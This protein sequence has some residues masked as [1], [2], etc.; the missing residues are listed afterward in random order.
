[1]T[2]GE[3]YKELGNLDEAL[4]SILKSQKLSPDNPDIYM[5]L[6]IIYLELGKLDQALTSTLNL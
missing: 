1:M 2:L 6:G 4:N 5:N 3:I